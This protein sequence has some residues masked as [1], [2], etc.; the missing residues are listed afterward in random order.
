MKYILI[1]SILMSIN[2]QAQECTLTVK[3]QTK[4]K[5]ETAFQ[6]KNITE[7]RELALKTKENHFFGLLE[8]DSEVIELKYL[9]KHENGPIKEVFSF[10]P[11]INEDSI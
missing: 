3:T 4:E 9:F 7:C 8:K 11:S 2:A 10:G 1:A 6:T 5:L